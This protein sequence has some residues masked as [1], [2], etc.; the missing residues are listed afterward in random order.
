MDDLVWAD[1]ISVPADFDSV[2]RWFESSLPS[3][4]KVLCIKAFVVFIALR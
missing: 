2:I 1:V 4:A 3:H